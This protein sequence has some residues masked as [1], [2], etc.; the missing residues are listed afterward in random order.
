MDEEFKKFRTLLGLHY[1]SKKRLELC[2]KL[3]CRMPIYSNDVLQCFPGCSS[4]DIDILARD[5][6]GLKDNRLFD[7]VVDVFNRNEGRK[8]KSDTLRK[9]ISIKVDEILAQMNRTHTTDVYTPKNLLDFVTLYYERDK[10]EKNGENQGE[11]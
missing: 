8:N 2:L 11:N 5:Y 4:D 6:K 9:W 10:Q 3:K 7:Q 1:R